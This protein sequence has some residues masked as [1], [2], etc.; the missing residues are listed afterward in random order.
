[1]QRRNA[2]G[3]AIVVALSVIGFAVYRLQA[4]PG[5]PQAVAWD[6]ENCTECHM[7]ISDR[8]F[9]AQ[10]QT[11]DG[12]TRNFDDPACLM[13]YVERQHP[14]VHTIYFRDSQS[15]AWL[16]SEETGFVTGHS[17]MGHGLAAVSNATPGALSYAAAL[18]F[19]QRANA[20]PGGL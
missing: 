14:P 6:R 10:L 7:L 9:T 4:L 1:M 18:E 12:Q 8:H 13:K 17:P 3:L 2:V 19:M 15:G 16:R 11:A 5:G 20:S